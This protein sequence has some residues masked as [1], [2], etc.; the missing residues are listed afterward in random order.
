VILIAAL[1]VGVNVYVFA[2]RYDAG[3][4]ESA[5]AILI[6]NVLSVITLPLV[7]LWLHVG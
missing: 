6:S 3:Q 4:A 2:T 1:P 7:L 5:A